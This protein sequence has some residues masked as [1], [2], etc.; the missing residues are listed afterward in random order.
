M[1]NIKLLYHCLFYFTVDTR[2]F[3]IVVAHIIFLLDNDNL[4]APLRKVGFFVY[5]FTK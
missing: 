4:K 3:I 5:T 1:E 2:I